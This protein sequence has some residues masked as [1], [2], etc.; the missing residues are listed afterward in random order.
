MIYSLRKISCRHPL[1]QSQFSLCASY[2]ALPDD[3]PD[4][5]CTMCEGDTPCVKMYGLRHA[6]V[7]QKRRVLAMCWT[8][9]DTSLLS[10]FIF[11][12]GDD[13]L[14]PSLRHCVFEHHNQEQNIVLGISIA[15]YIWFNEPDRALKPAT[16]CGCLYRCRCRNGPPPCRP[17]SA[18][19]KKIIAWG[20]EL[21]KGRV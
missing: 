14:T 3:S 20:H 19:A 12:T 5:D 4:G 16:A 9:D 17:M 18:A 11:T 2:T 15:T 8:I 10:G 6:S 13:G 7:T 21:N 1:A